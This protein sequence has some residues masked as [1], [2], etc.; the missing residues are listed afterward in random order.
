MLQNNT[1]I[2]VNH[3]AR[4]ENG[5]VDEISVASL[6]GLLADAQTPLAHNQLEVT[7]TD[8]DKYTQAEVT[9]LISTHAAIA[10]AHQDAP[11]LISTHTALPNAHHTAFVQGDADLLY[12][13]IGSATGEVAA[14]AALTTGIHGVG[15]S[16]VASVNDISI[17]AGLPDVHHVAFVQGDADLLYEVIN[18]VATHVA[19]PDAHIQYILVAGTRAFTGEQSM[20]SNKLTNL[21]TPTAGADAATKDYVDSLLQGLDWQESVKDRYDPTGGLP[22]GPSTGDRYI[23]T[24][25]ANGWT[26]NNIYEYNGASWDESPVDEGFAT[27]VED[28]DRLYV[29]NGTNWVTFGTTTDHGSLLGLGDDDHTQYHTDGR[30]ATWLAANHETTY[31]HGNYNT[32]Y[33]WGDHAGLYLPIGGGTLTGTLTMGNGASINLE[34]DITWTGATGVNLAKFPD[35]LEVALRFAEGSNPYLDFISTDGVERIHSHK[36]FVLTAGKKFIL[37]G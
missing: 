30:A 31:N 26:N 14:H 34:E 28:E 13:P 15:G 29:Y 3:A 37:D 20:G 5:G 32:A 17:H 9:G 4:H 36:D 2:V 12:D 23:A 1:T 10:T 27:W 8:L 18:A 35:N 25:T 11:G 16:T 24:A 6:S 22:G 7:I 21:S 33:G 19:L